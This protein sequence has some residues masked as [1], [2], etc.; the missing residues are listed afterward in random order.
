M[1]DLLFFLLED[2]SA[3]A[4]PSV[5]SKIVLLIYG[6]LIFYINTTF[7]SHPENFN[8]SNS[9]KIRDSKESR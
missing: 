3:K 1:C 7:K 5:R 2:L 9:E 6:K 4:N 8:D